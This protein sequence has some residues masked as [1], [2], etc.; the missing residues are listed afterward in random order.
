MRRLLILSVATAALMS[1][2][3]AYADTMAMA[4]R[5]LNVRAGPGT[6]NPIIG[7]VGSG[8]SVN[9][10]GCEQSGRWCTV[11]FDGGEGWVSAKY[12]SGDFNAGQVVV[13]EQPTAAIRTTRP[14]SP[15]AGTGAL[16]GGAG[17][18]VAG[19]VIGGPVGAAVGGVAGVIAGGTT[20]SVLDPP[21]RVRTYV[22]AHRLQPVYLDNQITVG[23]SLPDTVELREIPDYQYRYVYVNDRPMLVEPGSRRVVYVQ[24]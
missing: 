6:Q 19:A 15:A 4:N 3:A 10:R 12:L 1:A 17:G 21:R 9:I 14:A 8:Q 16:V 24:Q 20:G 18:A 22:S 5:D 11:A 2:G 13:T 23:S 7:V